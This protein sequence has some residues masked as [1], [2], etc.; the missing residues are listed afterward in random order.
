MRWLKPLLFANFLFFSTGYLFLNQPGNA[1]DEPGHVSYIRYWAATG[2]LPE[3]ERSDYW[4]RYLAHHPPLYYAI[5]RVLMPFL[6]TQSIPIQ[7]RIL[8]SIGL[9]CHLLMLW[10]LLKIAELV[11]DQ[12]DSLVLGTLACAAL[13]PMVSFIGASI[14]NDPMNNLWMALV[15]WLAL[16]LEDQPEERST[17]LGLG[18]V[19]GL[20]CSTKMTAVIPCAAVVTYLGVR[21]RLSL[22]GLALTIGMFVLIAGQTFWRNQ[23]LLGDPLGITAIHRMEPVGRGWAG[24]GTYVLNAF[25]S[26]WAVTGWM[27]TRVGD[28]YYLALW[29]FVLVAVMGLFKI[30]SSDETPS[31]KHGPFLMFVGGICLLQGLAHGLSTMQTQGR[32]LFA[33]LG[34]LMP[35]L[36]AGFYE[37]VKDIPAKWRPAFWVILALASMGLQWQALA[38]TARSFHV[39]PGVYDYK[40]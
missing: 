21:K 7:Y 17:V 27:S 26:F 37:A 36:F 5:G 20:A 22:K 38:R 23:R 1:P 6:Q 10:V 18:L 8:R 24:L 14:S 19:I 9:L 35:L 32:Y 15:V 39:I 2:Q 33:G 25:Q 13:N 31:F 34:A 3:F 16:R 40:I 11:F 30:T 29:A 12:E 4:P 28:G